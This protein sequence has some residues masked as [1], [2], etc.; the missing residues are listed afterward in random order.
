MSPQKQ[1]DNSTID[2][3][4]ALSAIATSVAGAALVPGSAA[5]SD[6]SRVKFCDCTKVCFTGG[7]PSDYRVW[8]AYR[9]DSG[10]TYEK[11]TV[12]LPDGQGTLCYTVR[13]AERDLGLTRADDAKLIAVSDF[14]KQKQRYV[15]NPF[16]CGAEPL[17][18]FVNDPPT[19]IPS[20][21]NG[22][23]NDTGTDE[24]DLSD[25]TYRGTE[26][27]ADPEK[28][29]T[30]CRSGES[31]LV[32]YEW[33][34]DGFTTEEGSDDD[35]SI[36]F[37]DLDEDGEPASVSLTTSYCAVDAVVTA[38]TE[39]EVTEITN[40]GP[41]D[42]NTSPDIAYFTLE[43][44]DGKAISNVRFYCEAPETVGVG[45]GNAT[46]ARAKGSD[47]GLLMRWLRS[48]LI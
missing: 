47:A 14:S 12:F 48:G 17:G 18:A 33:D 2:R 5:A 3:R 26:V 19:D 8:V 22:F 10:W 13:E 46:S 21:F 24:L 36:E 34:G 4:T 30:V 41:E 23:I 35:I 7:D 20:P 25:G 15:G 43:G 31:P 11:V 28:C 45:N 27:V 40:D 38:G 42:M 39:Y 1:R 9:D 37:V 16:A 44:I 32:K 29:C 6:F